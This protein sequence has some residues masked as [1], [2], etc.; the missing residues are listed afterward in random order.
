MMRKIMILG[1]S[2]L[3]LPAIEKAK[4]MGLEVIAV[5]MNPDAVGFSVDGVIKEVISTIDTS[6]VLEAARRHKI[7]GIMTLAS[8]MPMQTVAVVSHELGLVGISEDTAL[9]ATN[10]AYMR[11]ALKAANVP[12]PMYFRVSNKEDFLQA[13]SE[14]HKAGYMLFLLSV[15]QTA[16]EIT[17]MLENIIDTICN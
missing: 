1:A 4:E 11:D 7:D 12:I 8:D 10:K 6:A 15:K 5:D 16:S 9:K 3:Q 14:I 2:I 13:V 17:D